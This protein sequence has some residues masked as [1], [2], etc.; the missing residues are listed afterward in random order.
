MREI[1][2]EVVTVIQ[3]RNDDGLTRTVTKAQRGLCT[4]LTEEN[5]SAN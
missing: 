3:A 4:R 5:L 1:S 2:W